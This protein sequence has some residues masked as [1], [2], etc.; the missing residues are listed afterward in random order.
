MRDP[1]NEVETSSGRKG[2]R[3]RIGSRFISDCLRE[4]G[5]SLF[6]I[7]REVI[8]AN[9]DFLK[10]SIKNHFDSLIKSIS[11]LANYILQICTMQRS[12]TECFLAPRP[13][14]S[15]C[16]SRVFR[17]RRTDLQTFLKWK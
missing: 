4:S 7:N 17:P 16:R 5:A 1:G 6:K 9:P 14:I 8:E 11:Y 15:R 12:M 13:E 10:H 3:V 2:C